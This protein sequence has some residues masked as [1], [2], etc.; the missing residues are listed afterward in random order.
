M[1]ERLLALAGS[2]VFCLGLAAVGTEPPINVAGK[3][4]MIFLKRRGGASV[5][6][7][8]LNQ[9]AEELLGTVRDEGGTI[10]VRGSITGNSIHL[11]GK[12]MVTV[13]FD[14]TI[15]KG[16]MTGTMRVLSLNPDFS[17]IS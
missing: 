6:T 14:A 12:H 1:T 9:K 11:S 16:K 2:F 10:P 15:E 7:L 8:T 3:W 17:P 13:E 4:K 5:K